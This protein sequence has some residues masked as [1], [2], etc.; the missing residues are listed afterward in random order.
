MKLLKIFLIF[1]VLLLIIFS[2]KKDVTKVNEDNDYIFNAPISNE[3]LPDDLIWLTNDN[4]PEFASSE[5]EKGGTFHVSLLSY[6]LTFRVVGPDSNSSFRSYIL[7]NQLLLINIHPNTENLIPELAT[8]WAYD[9]DNKTMY[10][11]LNK[12]ARWSDG[13][14][15]TAH[16]FAYTLEFMRSK[17][18]V[19]PWY[20][21]F[22]TKDIDKVTV[23]D[24]YTLS[25]S[26]TRVIPDL[27][28]YV[29]IRPIARHFY[30]KLIF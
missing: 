24:D 18:I 27:W 14:P 11:K 13:K 21:D 25:I 20:N 1:I 3:K 30:G 7:D 4:D 15:V 19:A 6:P 5:A 22:Y 16:D 12:N 23:Y 29:N 9:N 17:N 8:H 28:I 26:A 2:C 10:F